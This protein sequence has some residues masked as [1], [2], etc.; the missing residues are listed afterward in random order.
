MTVPA[1]RIM[2]VGLALSGRCVSLA[3]V[4][5]ASGD[6]GDP[7]LVKAGGKFLVNWEH[8]GRQVQLELS[9]SRHRD[10]FHYTDRPHN[11]EE[12]N[13]RQGIDELCRCHGLIF[14]VD[15]QQ[16][17]SVGCQEALATLRRDFESRGR[18]LGEVPM[19]FQVNK[20]D[21]SRTCPLERVRATLWNE[22]ADYIESV[23]IRGKGTSEAINALL[24]RVVKS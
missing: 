8:R 9:V 18:D 1:V 7:L 20:R 15:S 4:Q 22:N 12:P 14:V 24:D 16:A 17:R 2:Y 5:T 19:V 13:V 23:A 6:R 21:L 3:A 11:I 10:V